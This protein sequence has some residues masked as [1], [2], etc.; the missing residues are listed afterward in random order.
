MA[1]FSIPRVRVAG[2]A[3][4][5]PSEIFENARYNLISDKDLALLIKTIGVER[6]RHASKGLIS[7]DLCYHAA[8]KLIHE[9]SWKKDEIDLLV[10]VSQTRD[11]LMPATSCILQDRLSLSKKCM[12]FDLDL[13]CSGYVYGLSVVFSLLSTGGLRKALLLAGEVPTPNS[14]YKDKS[15]FPL[16]GDAGTAT[17]CEYD[18]GAGESFFNL[19]TDG[20][21]YKA[22]MI[23]D[24]GM[25]NYIDPRLTFEESMI[26]DGITRNR[27]QIALD[28]MAVFNFALRE[29]RPNIQ[30]LMDRSGKTLDE[31][32]Y[33]VFHQANRLMNETIRKQLKIPSEK[34]LYSIREFGNTSSASIPLTLNYAAADQLRNERLKLLLSGFGVG[35]SWGSVY[36]ETE[37][38]VCTDIVELPG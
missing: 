17:A 13:G 25:R 26:T 10:F 37:N 3:S 21:G 16:F 22:I 11:Y 12:A 2:I 27:A 5:V 28:G 29:V 6:K 36:T 8:E 7:S 31:V 4:C 14:S 38:V 1:F 34:Y 30:E 9:I 35:L 19:Q 20:S 15:V 32:D 24:G 23:P 18:S 33:F